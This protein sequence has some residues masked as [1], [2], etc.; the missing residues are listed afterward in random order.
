MELGW[1]FFGPLI[2]DMLAAADEF[3]AYELVAVQ[4]SLT[5]MRDVVAE[6]QAVD[7]GT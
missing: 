7:P 5:A 4:R 6:R 1:S 2:G 3:T